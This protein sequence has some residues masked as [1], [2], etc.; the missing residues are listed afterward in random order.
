MRD[1]NGDIVIL[2][3]NFK[4]IKASKIKEVTALNNQVPECT[5]E[6]ENG[7]KIVLPLKIT[8]FVKYLKSICNI[9]V[10]GK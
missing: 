1:S 6:L 5:C 7:Q 2:N 3:K 9:N 10:I 8:S 4:I